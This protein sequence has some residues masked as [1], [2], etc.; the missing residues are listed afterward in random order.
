MLIDCK[1]HRSKQ[2]HFNN[3]PMCTQ[4]DTEEGAL[5]SQEF[6]GSLSAHS[7]CIIWVET[8]KSTFLTNRAFNLINKI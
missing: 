7:R 4:I 3:T 2:L 5:I 6:N 1:S 8:Q